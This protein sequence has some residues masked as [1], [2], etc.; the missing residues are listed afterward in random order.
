VDEA[1]EWGA[2]LIVAD[3]MAAGSVAQAVAAHAS[4]SVEVVRKRAS[5]FGAAVLTFDFVVLAHWRL[6]H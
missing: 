4:Y 2:D 3:E 1:Q 6:E 5:G